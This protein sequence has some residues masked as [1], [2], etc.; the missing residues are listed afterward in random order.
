MKAAAAEQLC[1]DVVDRSIWRAE[2]NRV[3]VL[4][5]SMLLTKKL[6]VELKDQNG[7][8]VNLPTCS[9]NWCYH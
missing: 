7:I 6:V 4:D 1:V 2:K 9:F 8:L 5:S 3:C